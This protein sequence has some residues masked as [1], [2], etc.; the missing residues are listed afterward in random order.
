M[1]GIDWDWQ[2]QLETCK[3]RIVQLEEKIASERQKLQRLLAGN[4]NPTFAQRMLAMREES[5]ERVQSCKRLIETRITDRAADRL[6]EMPRHD[7]KPTS[8]V[9]GASQEFQRQSLRRV[10]TTH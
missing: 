7:E 4:R 8:Q 2:A 1:N 10:A 5:L 6:V 3:R 9:V